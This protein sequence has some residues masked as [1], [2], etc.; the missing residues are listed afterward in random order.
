MGK[1][2]QGAASMEDVGINWIQCDS[3]TR[4]E[5]YEN[6]GLAGP[7]DEDK[8][9]VAKFECRFCGLSRHLEDSRNEITSLN[10]KINQLETKVAELVKNSVDM[11]AWT[12]VVKEI[13]REIKD[14][15]EKVG[16]VMT[17]NASLLEKIGQLE[18]KTTDLTKNNT[19]LRTWTDVVKE[20]PKEFEEKIHDVQIRLDEIG[21]K[22]VTVQECVE[23]ALKVQMQEDRAEEAERMKRRTSVI[24]HGMVE[25]QDTVPEKR[26]EEDGNRVQVMLHE[27]NCDQVNVR[28][29]IRLGK[30][31]EGADAKARPI[32]MVLETEDSKTKV[33]MRAKNLKGKEGGLEHVFLHQDLTPK[34]RE[35]RKVLV[36]EI[37]ERRSR[38]ESDLIIINGRIVVKRRQEH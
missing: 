30:R 5:I 8:V 29:V 25:S 1:K 20:L 19:E 2:K 23:G 36:Q 15:K 32:K 35:A 12:D 13:P 37:K 17:D 3:C 24:I 38:G 28:K 14:N 11:K 34:E 9:G 6:S 26:E 22:G 18:N 4:W 27:M 33:L 7:Y 21:K 31:Q 16:K 10:K